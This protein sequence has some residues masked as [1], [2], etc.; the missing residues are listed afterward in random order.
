MRL[1]R[2]F[3]DARIGWAVEPDAAPLLRHHE[4][5]PEPLLFPRRGG[6]TL[7][8]RAVATLRDFRPDLVV[9]VQGNTKSGTV[10]RLAAR[11]A[12][13]L[14]F[15]RE[16]AREW[17]NLAFSTVKAPPSGAVHSVRRN[18]ALLRALGVEPQE[19]PPEYGFAVDDDERAEGRRALR[20]AG[21]PDGSAVALLHPGRLRDVRTWTGA[22]FAE[23][24]R[25]LKARGWE[26]VLEGP[27]S[28]RPAADESVLRDAVT[29]GA[30]RD[31]GQDLSLRALGGL[32]DELASERR[33]TGIPHV[34][35]SPD[36]LLPHLAA[37]CGLPVVLLAGPQDPDRTG[38]LG[39]A[40]RIVRA[41]EGLTCAP[42]RKRRCHIEEDRACMRRI[43][44]ESV[45]R[46]LLELCPGSIAGTAQ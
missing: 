23:L 2:R 42:C 14:G 18:L 12:P 41:W 26:P 34:L 33:R 6:P 31:L 28:D 1:H 44:A 20:S 3:P 37:A 16:D 27:D 22:G 24:A 21:V 43:T 7:R 38:P 36:T 9:D 10:S 11:G 19:G 25:R 29:A 30:A 15:G 39:T 32:V 45:E 40:T 17:A 46:A 5:S 13:I 4:A 8:A 35:V